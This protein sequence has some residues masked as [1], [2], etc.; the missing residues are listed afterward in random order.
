M[1]CFCDENILPYFAEAPEV[2]VKVS[3]KVMPRSCQDKFETALRIFFF[4][5]DVSRPKFRR[6]IPDINPIFLESN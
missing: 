6:L 3:G 2:N 4:F 1:K 5:A